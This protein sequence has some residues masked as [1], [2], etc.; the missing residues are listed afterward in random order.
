MT[1]RPS[2]DEVRRRALKPRDSWWTVFV[3]DPVAI[4]LTALA[5]RTGAPRG[6]ARA[7]APSRFPMFVRLRDALV[8]RRVRP[9]LFSG[10][11]FQMAVF[12]V[13]PLSG[14]IVPVTIVAA[15]LLLVFE[16]ALVADLL[17]AARRPG[18]AR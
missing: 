1:A 12:I 6:P 16:A 17:L 13:G 5:E 9:H 10:V 14:A 8:A 3:V 4:R 11:E 2:L 7:G 18:S 15:G